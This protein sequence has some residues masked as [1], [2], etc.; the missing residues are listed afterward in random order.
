MNRSNDRSTGYLAIHAAATRTALN[1]CIARVRRTGR[2][3]GSGSQAKRSSPGRD[4]NRR[5]RSAAAIDRTR[6]PVRLRPGAADRPSGQR[7]ANRPDAHGRG[8]RQCRTGNGLAHGRGA[9]QGRRGRPVDLERGGQIVDGAGQ[10][11]GTGGSLRGEFRPR[12]GAGHGQDG[13]QRGHLPRLAQRQERLQALAARL[14]PAVRS[15][16]ADRRHRRPAIQPGGARSEPDA[17][18]GLGLDSARGRSA[19]PTGRTRTTSCCGPGL[20]TA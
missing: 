5:H 13:L 11:G 17:A 18:Q 20:P 1:R 12:R 19:D 15:P 4:R 3:R 9:A 10:S 8:R 14:R 6:Q 16:R 7:R 2:R